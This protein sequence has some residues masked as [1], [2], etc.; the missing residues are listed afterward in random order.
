VRVADFDYEL[1]DELIALRPAEPRDAARLLV[2][3]GMSRA[4]KVFSDLPGLLK[5][6]DL[7]VLNDTRVLRARLHATRPARVDG[8]PAV[9]IELLLH[10][11]TGPASWEA[12][13]RPA[14][15]LRAN[16]LLDFGNGLLA[17]VM[18]RGEDGLV[19]LAFERENGALDVAIDS[20]GEVPLPSYIA[21]RRKA[22]SRDEA[23]YQTEFAEMRGAVAAPTAGL[24]FTPELFRA[25]EKRGLEGVTVT[26]HVGGGTFLPVKAEDTKQHVMYPEWG[27]ITADA[28]DAINAVRAAGGRIV[29]VGTTSLRLLESA[30]DG[31]G[32]VRPFEGDT[33]LFIAPGY[34]IRTADILI[35]NFHLPRSTLLML[36][37]AFGGIEPMRAA[38]AHA[39]AQRY[40]FYSYGDACLIHRAK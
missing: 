33:R 36:V 22:D 20:V 5:S 38:Y 23:D 39:I 16:D 1:P 7:L 12:F 6:G 13:A 21:S 35:T 17:R 15:R 30:A 8:G 40:R 31:A 19:S 29:A 11:R 10:H 34:R 9:A 2:I 4:D 26:L 37:R 3:D 28:A 24:H 27:R 18:A 32:V 25:L 14:K